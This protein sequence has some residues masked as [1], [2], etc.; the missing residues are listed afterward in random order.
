MKH[1]GKMDAVA[2]VQTGFIGDVILAT[3]LLES[4]RLS[5]PQ[6]KVVAV[7]RSGCENLLGNN[8]FVD[9]ILVWDKKGNEKGI[10]GIYRM[11][12]KLSSFHITTALIP[13]RSFRSGLA[14]FLSGAEKRI[15][16]ARGGGAFFH[17]KKVH[18]RLGIHE[19]ERNL[20]LAKAAGWYWKDL[21]PA[22]FPD[23]ADKSVVDDFLYGI[24]SFCVFAP[25]SVWPTKRWP[26][27]FYRKTGEY[28]AQKGLRVIISGGESDRDLCASLAAGIPGAF[29]ACNVLTLRQSAELYRRSRFV[30]TGDSAPQ[31]LAAAVNTTVFSIFG[32][33]DSRY[34]FWPYSEK[35]TVIE[36]E[37][38]C[39]PCGV[40]GHKSCPNRTNECMKRI[41]S[42]EVV[43][44]IEKVV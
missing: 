26:V 27:E 8:P 2:V 28:F 11:A 17:T 31:H 19:V 10:A 30:L 33:T 14:L 42:E 34:G 6:E 38:N 15:G 36:A 37:V 3:P 24:D 21:K 16:F 5:R 9:E 13:H 25:G 12:K 23:E 29:D 4:A 7:V 41:T 40:H 35:G 32:P 18:Y 43:G 44:I 22:V 1:G 20:L 39:R